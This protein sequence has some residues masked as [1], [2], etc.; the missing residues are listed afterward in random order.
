MAGNLNLACA[1]I[2]IMVII[3]LF[4]MGVGVRF[5]SLSTKSNL[6]ETMEEVSEVII[7]F[8]LRVI[9]KEILTTRTMKRIR[10]TL[11]NVMQ[12]LLNKL[13]FNVRQ[14]KKVWRA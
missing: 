5:V 6:L 10:V 8:H 9:K 12:D 1:V 3:P 13:Y 14:K 11:Y 4:L 2:T 7:L